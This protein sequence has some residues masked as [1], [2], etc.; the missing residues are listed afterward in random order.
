MAGQL[1]ARQATPGG[2]G[3]GALAA[4]IGAA[5]GRWQHN[6]PPAKNGWIVK[7]RVKNLIADLEQARRFLQAIDDDAQAYAALQASWRNNSLSDVNERN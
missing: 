4:A 6:T 7:H 1:A 3:S 2:G 5:V